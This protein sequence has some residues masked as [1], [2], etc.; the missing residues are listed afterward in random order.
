ML[1]ERT[2]SLPRL[3]N[4]R[5][6]AAALPRFFFS[7]LTQRERASA[8]PFTRAV[9]CIGGGAV[10]V[11]DGSTSSSLSSCAQKTHFV[12]LF[13]ACAGGAAEA[14]CSG[15][16]TSATRMSARRARTRGDSGSQPTTPRLFVN[17]D[18]D[19]PEYIKELQRPAAIKVRCSSF[20]LNHLSFSLVS[21]ALVWE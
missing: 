5:R 17:L 16:A 9:P 3:W 18:P 2:P 10:R 1:Y 11:V 7:S 21:I 6:A 20:F 19:D 15:S 13:G 4:M 12:S 14:A 8:F